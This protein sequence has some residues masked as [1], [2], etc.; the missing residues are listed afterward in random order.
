MHRKWR[1]L[2]PPAYTRVTIM[3]RAVHRDRERFEH[4]LAE[5]KDHT[6]SRRSPQEW[7]RVQ[8]A[9]SEVHQHTREVLSTPP[10]ANGLDRL[11][12]VVATVTIQRDNQNRC[13]TRIGGELLALREAGGSWQEIADWTN[14]D[15]RTVRTLARPPKPKES[16]APSPVDEDLAALVAQVPANPFFR[17]CELLTMSRFFEAFANELEDVTD[18]LCFELS[19]GG[20][21]RSYI[22]RHAHMNQ[23]TL[24]R[25]INRGKRSGWSPRSQRSTS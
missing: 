24:A 13:R 18:W 9:D 19:T 8:L 21:D 5:W 22:A 11:S 6:W 25:R 23:L 14:M 7:S 10:A 4:W 15:E 17:V 20:V 3:R 12:T 16:A 1:D 2:V